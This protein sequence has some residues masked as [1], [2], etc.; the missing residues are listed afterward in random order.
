VKPGLTTGDRATFSRIVP[1]QETVSRLFAD[2]VLLARMP[3]V[4]ATAYMVGFMEWAC[5]EHIAPYHEDGECSLGVLVN[6]SHVAPTPPGMRVTVSST[7]T[8]VDGRF[9]DFAV[10]AH[11]AAGLIGEGTHRRAVVETERFAAKAAAK[12]RQYQAAAG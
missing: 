7:V 5:C 2:S 8:A 12:G 1:P 3:D 6:M 10:V 9:V 11:D 4:Y